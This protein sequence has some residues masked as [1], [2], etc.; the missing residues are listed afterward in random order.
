MR[1]LVFSMMG[2]VAAGATGARAWSHSEGA[3]AR[4]A[5]P[6]SWVS[7][8]VTVD[9]E[10]MPLY[11]DPGGTERHYVEARK[12]G[13]Y[14]LHLSNRTGERLGVSLAVDGLNVIDGE[15]QGAGPGRMYVLGPW[16]TTSIRGWR[17]SL[18]EI[19]GFTFVDEKTSYAAR[20]GKANG[21]MGWIEMVVYRDLERER[22]RDRGRIGGFEERESGPAAPDEARP[23][24]QNQKDEARRAP[25]A[26]APSAGSSYPGTGWGDRMDDHVRL[27]EFAPEPTPSERLTVR[28]EYHAALVAL[29][30]IPDYARLYQ[31]EHGESGFAKPPRY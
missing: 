19:R 7:L 28:Y 9:G 17:T 1:I 12:N 16:E 25:K 30:V 6:G 21:K 27:V 22:A 23:E 24:A 20:S 31:R 13:R 2:I 5:E 26:A 4:R 10:M 18:E 3:A 11:R 8:E 29:G 14:E 15:R